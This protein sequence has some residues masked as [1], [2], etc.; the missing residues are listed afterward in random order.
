MLVNL[1]HAGR[2]MEQKLHGHKDVDMLISTIVDVQ[3]KVPY[4]VHCAGHCK[5]LIIIIIII[6][7]II[8]SC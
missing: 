1:I 6:I 2:D 7:M 4:T 8:L 3:Q 5:A